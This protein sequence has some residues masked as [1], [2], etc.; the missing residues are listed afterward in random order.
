MKQ[1]TIFNFRKILATTAILFG[2]MLTTILPAFGQ[3][4]VDLT[5]E[6]NV[7]FGDAFVGC[8]VGTGCGRNPRQ[9]MRR[10]STPLR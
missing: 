7:K 4:D 5:S 6:A 10:P 2:A 9:P 1:A 3:Q 8:S